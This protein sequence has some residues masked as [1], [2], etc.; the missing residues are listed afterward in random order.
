MSVRTCPSLPFKPPGA[1]QAPEGTVRTRQ[2]ASDNMVRGNEMG[3][4]HRS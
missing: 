1:A 3:L 2:K 4:A